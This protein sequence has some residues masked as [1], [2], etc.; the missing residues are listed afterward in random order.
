LLPN[1]SSDMKLVKEGLPPEWCES[2]ERA[3]LLHRLLHAFGFAS[4]ITAERFV[5][6][7]KQGDGSSEVAEEPSC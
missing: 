1:Q 4:T 6:C 5:G 7:S 2:S 3:L